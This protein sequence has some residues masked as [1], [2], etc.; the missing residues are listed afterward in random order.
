VLLVLINRITRLAGDEF[1]ILLKGLEQEACVTFTLPKCL[2]NLDW[3][4]E[5]LHE[6]KVMTR[7]LSMP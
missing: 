1:A 6:D 4:I 3:R 5:P 2:N 7:K